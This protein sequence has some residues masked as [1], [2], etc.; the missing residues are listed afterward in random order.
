MKSSDVTSSSSSSTDDYDSS[1][2]ERFLKERALRKHRLLL[3]KAV[4][5]EKKRKEQLLVR[6]RQAVELKRRARRKRNSAT[7]GQSLAERIFKT[8]EMNSLNKQVGNF[9]F[10]LLFN[11]SLRHSKIIV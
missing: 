1:E 8:R 3:R 2:E 10:V 5:E 6:W 11:T 4:E 7:E 9:E